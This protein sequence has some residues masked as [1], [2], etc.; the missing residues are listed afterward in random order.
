[1]P[2][3]HTL[4]PTPTPHPP[5]PARQGFIEFLSEHVPETLLDEDPAAAAPIDAPPA[6]PEL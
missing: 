4:P 1:M 2:V 5:R 6:H 3:I